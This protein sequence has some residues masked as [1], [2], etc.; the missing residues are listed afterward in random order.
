MSLT[1]STDNSITKL[2]PIANGLSFDIFEPNSLNCRTYSSPNSFNEVHEDLGKLAFNKNMYLN[3]IKT[4]TLTEFKAYCNLR[5]WE[6]LSLF[7]IINPNTTY[8]GKLGNSDPKYLNDWLEI[9]SDEYKP[10]LSSWD[11]GENSCTYPSNVFLEFITD[12][13][14]SIDDPA[15]YIFSAKMKN[16]NR[17]VIFNEASTTIDMNFS[18]IVNYI[19]SYKTS[20]VKNLRDNPS[21]FPSLPIDIV[22]P[23]SN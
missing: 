19:D 17:T 12:R 15:N 14:G 2:L 3:C 16:T 10:Y 18:F 11:E 9:I 5:T 22:N 4:L 8:I 23:F 21:I 7:N 20:L 6:S 1:Q 13:T